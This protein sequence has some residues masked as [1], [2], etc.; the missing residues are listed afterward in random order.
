MANIIAPGYN[1]G[2]A[3]T[4]P[5]FFVVGTGKAG[6]TS[7][8]RYL[9]QHP[10]IYMSPVK[11]PCYFAAEIRPQKLGAP[12]QRHLRMQTKSLPRVLGDGKPVSPMGWLACDWDD[13]LRLFQHVNGQR[14]IG[15][16]SAAYLWSETAPGNIAA[17]VPD[18]KIVMILRDPA[19]RA[20][21]QYLHQVSVGLTSA[22]FREHLRECSRTQTTLGI[23]HPFLEVGLYAGQVKRY[24]ERFPRE[25][26]RIYWYEEAW[27][28]PSQLLAD[29]F[30]FLGVD[31]FAADTSL[32]SLERRA[33]RFR[34]AHY[35]MKRLAVWYPLRALVPGPLRG[36][37]KRAAFRSGAPPMDPEDRRFLVDYYREDIGRLAAMTGRDLSAWLR[38]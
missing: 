23:H 25:H 19:E 32:R 34:A 35:W 27:R 16:S 17:C 33:P 37:L 3:A 8:H 26:V 21:S 24:L 31:A 14:A 36:S 9:A 22:S 7:L 1:L 5:N 20:Y 29:V 13:Y 10:Q 2:M 18:A 12:L 15:E 6:T 38:M 11:E 30:S 4:L 28:D